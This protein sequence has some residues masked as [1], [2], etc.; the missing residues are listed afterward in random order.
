MRSARAGFSLPERSLGAACM[1]KPRGTGARLLFRVEPIPLE[2][3]R[4]YFCRVASTHAYD[5][6]QWLPHLAGISGY[7]ADLDCEDH[8]QPIARALRLE[9]HEWLAMCYG[10]VKGRSEERRVGKECRSRWAP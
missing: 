5:T 8:R 9:P 10:R 7:K 3:P 2:S 4:G 1:T 6:P